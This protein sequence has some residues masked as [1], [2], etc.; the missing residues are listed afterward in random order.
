ME[1]T[2]VRRPGARQALGEA[3]D[4]SSAETARIF[5]WP[6][7][8]CQIVHARPADVL[9][10]TRGQDGSMAPRICGSKERRRENPPQRTYDLLQF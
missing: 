10:R 6:T 5:R 1:N 7:K 8:N 9:P 3:E 2:Y 4:P